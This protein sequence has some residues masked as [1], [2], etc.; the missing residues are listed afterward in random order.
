M[1]IRRNAAWCHALLGIL[2]LGEN[3]FPRAKA[4]VAEESLAAS[5]RQLVAPQARIVRFVAAH[6]QVAA[7][8]RGKG[9]D[10]FPHDQIV[11]P[12]LLVPRIG[13]AVFEHYLA[14]EVEEDRSGDRHLHHRQQRRDPPVPAAREIA[15]PVAIGFMQHASP[16]RGVKAVRLGKLQKHAVPRRIGQGIKA[17]DLRPRRERTNG[18][19]CQGRVQRTKGGGGCGSGGSRALPKGAWGSGTRA[20]V[21]G[22]SGPGGWRQLL[23]QGRCLPMSFPRP[24]SMPTVEPT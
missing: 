6:V 19:G 5:P 21:V 23:K 12:E 8:F 3:S 22:L 24:K 16:S 9:P 7:S 13:S 2:A 15:G 20:W 18:H 10:R 4:A 17:R 11:R 1:G 14:T